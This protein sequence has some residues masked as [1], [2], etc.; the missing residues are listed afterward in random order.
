MFLCQQQK[1]NSWNCGSC[2]QPNRNV[3]KSPTLGRCRQ[4]RG[5]CTRVYVRLIQIM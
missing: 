5:T 2:R 1:P 4:C 3:T